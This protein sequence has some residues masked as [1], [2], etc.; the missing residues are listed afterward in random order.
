MKGCDPLQM[1]TSILLWLILVV[2]NNLFIF[3]CVFHIFYL[4]QLARFKKMFRL[5]DTETVFKS[6]NFACM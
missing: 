2:T 4:E 3:L 6:Q 5:L 1:F